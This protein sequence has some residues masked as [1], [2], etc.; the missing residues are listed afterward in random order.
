MTGRAG[1]RAAAAALAAAAMAALVTA[2]AAEAARPASHAM[3][4]WQP[5]PVDTCPRSL[6][7]GYSVVGP[8]GKR[9]PTWHPMR[10]RDPASGRRCTF[11]HEHGRNPARS[12]LAGFI[13]SHLAAPGARRR[14]GIPFGLAA[15]ALDAYAAANPGT[16][17]RHED[18]VGHKVEWA[19]DVELERA[20]GGGRTEIGVACDFLTKIHQGSHSPDALGN[21]VHELLYAV[22][23]DDGTRLIATKLVAFGEPNEFVR[24][25]DKET[26]VQ[27]GT[28]HSFPAGAGMRLIPDRACAESH[29]LVGA[30]QYSQF[31]RGLYEDWISSNHL[32]TAGG[33]EVA[34]FDPHFAVFNPSRYGYEGGAL[35]RTIDLCWETEPNGDRARGGD[36]ADA[37][38]EAGDAPLAYD[39]PDSPFTGAHREVYFNQTT[40][41]NAAGPRRW[42]TDPYGGSASTERFPGA[43]CQLVG[44]VDNTDR[45]ILESQAFGAGRFY[46]GRGVHAPN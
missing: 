16:P 29:I 20:S 26:V 18:H 5:G 9:Y 8:D 24:A 11:G 39:D 17:T 37:R 21:N 10:T 13:A 6:H 30:G 41:D 25:C 42:W 45:P 27:A 34:Y 32:R 12:D 31:S 22:R 4:A 23:C 28:T 36:C 1:R 43:I 19:N 3:G 46:G 44:R 7:D 15:E 38:H 2:G 33:E 35:G 40:I 14:A